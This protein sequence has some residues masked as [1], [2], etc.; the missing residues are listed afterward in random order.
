[1]PISG[2][3]KSGGKLW[4]VASLR[5]ASKAI[6]PHASASAG[7]ARRM[8]SDC[9][10]NEEGVA[11]RSNVLSR[12]E[13]SVVFP[14]SSCGKIVHTQSPQLLP[15]KR[16]TVVS[17]YLFRSRRVLTEIKQDFLARELTNELN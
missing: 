17:A 11:I 16:R 8:T 5:K 3:G 1:M 12:V 10:G 14:C 13:G 6:A 7:T 15:R 4:S 2:E 9:A